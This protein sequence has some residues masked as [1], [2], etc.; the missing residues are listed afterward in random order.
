MLLYMEPMGDISSTTLSLMDARCAGVPVSGEGDGD[1]T[2]W[3]AQFVVISLDG[4]IF[5]SFQCNGRVSSLDHTGGTEF[6]DAWGLRGNQAT[7]P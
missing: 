3:D 5:Y 7:S 1:S 6:P 4:V 2:S